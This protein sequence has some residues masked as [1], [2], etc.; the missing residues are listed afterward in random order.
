M[1]GTG[2]F[3]DLL[4]EIL[5][6]EVYILAYVDN[7]KSKWY[8]SKNK[9]KI[10][11]SKE[12]QNYN[13]DYIIIAS[14]FNE[15]IYMQL[16]SMNICTD[17]I[18]QYSK[19]LDNY[20]SYYKTYI[21]LFISKPDGFYQVLVTGISYA[22]L[23]FRPYLCARKTMKFAFGS[24]DLFY[25]YHTIKYLIE[26]HK[27]K[28]YNVKHNIIGISYYSFQYD[29]SL[30]AMK[31]K[32]V[33]Y[34]EVLKNSHHFHNIETVYKE[35]G[36]NCEIADKLLKK[37][38]EGFVEA[39]WSSKELID[40][41]NK[42]S[43]GKKQAELD[44]HKN[45]PKTVEE[46]KRIFKNYLKLLKDNNIK[47]IVVVFPASKYYTKYFSK[48]IEDEFHS[49]MKQTKEEYEFQYIDYFR[50]DLFDDYDFTDVSHLNSK[51]AEKFTK[52]LNKEIQ[53]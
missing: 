9:K 19:F 7:D 33:L 25:D 6:N 44:C 21:N 31:G 14:Q 50:S 47:P 35:Y 53:W 1:F 16:V 51:G 43:L 39:K 13:Y 8:G 20:C 3:S 11:P 49:I 48:R 28:M 4:E 37:N 40:I 5:S 38:E 10:I 52:I 22:D 23:G 18:F 46:N 15:D 34:Y 27:N 36:L 2:N 17:K 41:D 32:T 30:S 26:N 12:I 45:Y 24:Q 42:E 29:M